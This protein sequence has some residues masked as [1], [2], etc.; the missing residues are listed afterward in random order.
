MKKLE[1]PKPK[2]IEKKVEAYLVSETRKLGGVAY[3]FTSPGRRGV[4]DRL[5]ILPGNRIAFVEVKDTQGKLTP[6]QVSAI[7]LL[8]SLDCEVKLLRSM[9]EVTRFLDQLAQKR[10]G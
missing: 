1:L 8:R 9:G 2:S 7:K 3:K 10:P 5:V 6:N 4:P